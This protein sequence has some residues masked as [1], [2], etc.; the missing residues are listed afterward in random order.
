MYL[1]QFFEISCIHFDPT[2]IPFI[3]LAQ[4]IEKML[5]I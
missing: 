3:G 2:T 5:E 4:Q 1:E